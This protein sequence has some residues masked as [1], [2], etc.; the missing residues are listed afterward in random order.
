LK[1]RRRIYSG[2][3]QADLARAEIDEHAR[4][5]EQVFVKRKERPV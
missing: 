5:A 2:E 4:P 3:P 1:S